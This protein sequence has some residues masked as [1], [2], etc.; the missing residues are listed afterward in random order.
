M[1]TAATE[2]DLGRKCIDCTH[3]ATV[4]YGVTNTPYCVDCYLALGDE[5]YTGKG[6][7][8]NA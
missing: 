1:N 7:W 6:E 3:K 2:I 8:L 4:G 5:C